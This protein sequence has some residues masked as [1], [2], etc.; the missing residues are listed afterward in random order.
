MHD[1]VTVCIVQG[2][3]HAGRDLEGPLRQEPPTTGQQLAQGHAIDV[4]HDDV[5]DD[6]CG[7]IA[8]SGEG[9]LARVI[10]GDDVRMIEGGC[11]LGLASKPS[12]EGRV[13]SKVW[14]QD[15]DRNASTEPEI[16]ALM[17]LGHSAASDDVADLIAVA[18][19]SGRLLGH[20]ASTSG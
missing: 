4:L 18:Q 14:A 19:H 12:L 8:L 2:G 9:V 17:N 16:L 20:A 1:P 11:R 10:H 5:W 3:Q 6:D 15:L 13:P 7:R